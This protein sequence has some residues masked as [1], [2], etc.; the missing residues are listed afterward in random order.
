MYTL[1]AKHKFIL[2]NLTPNYYYKKNRMQIFISDKLLWYHFQ[3]CCFRSEGKCHTHLIPTL[4]GTKIWWEDF[5]LL[6]RGQ[7]GRLVEGKA[8]PLGGGGGKLGEGKA[9]AGRTILTNKAHVEQEEHMGYQCRWRVDMSCKTSPQMC[10]S[11][12]LSRFLLKDRPLT[13]IHM[14][15]FMVLVTPWDSLSIMEKLSTLMGW[16]MV[17]AW[18]WIG[19]RALRCSLYL[20]SEIS[21][22]SPMYFAVNPRWSHL[23]LYITPLLLV[24][25]SLFWEPNKRFLIVLPSL[26]WTWIP[27]FVIFLK[28]SL[29]P[30]DEGT[31]IYM[32]VVLLSLS[33]CVLVL[34]LWPC[35]LRWKSIFI[36]SLLKTLLG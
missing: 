7:R 22:V 27:D 18:S 26:K 12:Y 20:S 32:F 23:N 6:R 15:S 3:Q 30:F 29:R 21:P 31:I 8:T 13:L 16:L 1:S 9:P 34:M 36:C 17:L 14:V 11:W 33:L 2:F 4:F 25:L 10:G 19:K 24:M 35:R 5:V 28:L